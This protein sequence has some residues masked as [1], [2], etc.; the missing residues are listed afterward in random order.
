MDTSPFLSAV[1]IQQY[2]SFVSALQWAVS[3]GNIDITKAVMT[4]SSFHAMPCQGHMYCICC[5]YGYLHN[6]N[7][8][9]IHFCVG[10]PDYSSLSDQQ[11][12]WAKSVYGNVTEDIPQDGPNPLGNCIVLT[13]YFDANL[14]HYMATCHCHWHFA[15]VQS[16]SD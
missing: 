11:F 1:E 2:Q 14:Y 4:M 16:D 8:A 10:E 12:D 6:M 13:H 3:I 15:L 5:I 9:A 7:Q